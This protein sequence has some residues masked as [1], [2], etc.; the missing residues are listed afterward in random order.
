MGA[1]RITPRLVYPRP[2][3]LV[4]GQ[5]GRAMHT[6][7]KH[8]ICSAVFRLRRGSSALSWYGDG[9]E[10]SREGSCSGHCC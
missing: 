4:A 2:C 8:Q 6:V 3:C 10:R 9:L 1:V 7:L 5:T